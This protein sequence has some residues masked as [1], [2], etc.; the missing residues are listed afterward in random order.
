LEPNE[1]TP[2]KIRATV[3]ELIAEI[4]E[5]EPAEISDTASFA[6]DLAIDSLA[7]ME[8]MVTVDKRFKVDI[9]EE[10]FAL[11]K[12]VN[13]AVELVQRHLAKAMNSASA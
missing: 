2:E 5:R 10:E 9:P 1:I 3:K 8:I 11:I 13:D 12:N 7:G 6:D 4:T